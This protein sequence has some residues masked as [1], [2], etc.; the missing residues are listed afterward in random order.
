MAWQQSETELKEKLLVAVKHLE[1]AHSQL[2]QRS[3]SLQL[4]MKRFVEHSTVAKKQAV[5]L[6]QQ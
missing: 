4:F 6:L 2:L 5:S 1:T 3:Q